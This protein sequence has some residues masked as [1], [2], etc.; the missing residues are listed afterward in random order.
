MSKQNVPLWARK[1]HLAANPK[2]EWLCPHVNIPNLG[3]TK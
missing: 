3:E 2:C 1:K